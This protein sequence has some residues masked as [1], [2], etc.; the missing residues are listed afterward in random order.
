[1]VSLA[2]TQINTFYVTLDTG[3]NDAQFSLQIFCHKIAS[4]AGRFQETGFN[5][6]RFL[7]HEIKHGIYFPLAGIYFGMIGNSLFGDNLFF[8][9]T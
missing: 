9:Y 3:F 6:L 1:M 8:R 7:F 4:A 5:L 2:Q